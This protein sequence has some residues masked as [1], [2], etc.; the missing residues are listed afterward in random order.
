MKNIRPRNRTAV[1]KFN[2]DEWIPKSAMIP[3]LHPD[4]EEKH[5]WP[6]REGKN[7]FAVTT[8]TFSILFLFQHIRST[9]T[10]VLLRKYFQKC[11]RAMNADK[12][13]D[14]TQTEKEVFQWE[15]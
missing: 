11:N 3:S 7:I 8:I 6:K 14:C 13:Y 1:A 15:K 10:S 2:N 9:R 5:E 12:M 4:F